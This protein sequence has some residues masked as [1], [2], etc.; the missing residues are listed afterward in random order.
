MAAAH[1]MVL[2]I[3]GSTMVGQAPSVEFLHRHGRGVSLR[4]P[5]G[6]HDR[7]QRT[8]LGLVSAGAG[9]HHSGQHSG[10]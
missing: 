7:E 8:V 2:A 5:K 6:G 9:A 10:Q 3:V 4:C 1:R